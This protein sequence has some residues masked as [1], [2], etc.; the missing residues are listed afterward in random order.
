MQ[1]T[2]VSSCYHFPVA[3]GVPSHP[4]QP[5]PAWRRHYSTHIFY[6][7]P[8]ASQSSM[9][10]LVSYFIHLTLFAT[11]SSPTITVRCVTRL[12]VQGSGELASTFVS[13]TLAR[14]RLRLGLGYKIEIVEKRI[15]NITSLARV[16]SLSLCDSELV[17]NPR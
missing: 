16:C 14:V 5:A 17:P 12:Y 9:L 4:H 15:E 13:P 10:V 2:H 8:I 1:Y 3:I 11:G 6:P 7:P